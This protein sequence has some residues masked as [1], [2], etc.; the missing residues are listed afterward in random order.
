MSESQMSLRC[1]GGKKSAAQAGFTLIELLTVIA[2]I[3]VLVALLIP[4]VQAI[5]ASARRTQCKN[6]LH[7]IG[8]AFDQFLDVQGQNGK[9]PDAAEMPSVSPKKKSIRTILAPYIEQ[10]SA[11]F[12]CP[13]DL[14]HF[15]VEGQSYDYPSARAVNKTRLQYLASFMRNATNSPTSASEAY[16]MYDYDGVHGPLLANPPHDRFFLYL[17]WHVDY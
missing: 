13:D 7:N 4:A 3:G 14:V 15:K 8:V 12:N 11:A 1:F 5:R 16:I 17:D 9:F 10:S 6:N 2:I